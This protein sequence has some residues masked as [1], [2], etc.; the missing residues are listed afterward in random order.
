MT[1]RRPLL[2]LFLAPKTA[3]TKEKVKDVAAWPTTTTALHQQE[4]MIQHSMLV[5]HH[6][7]L[8]CV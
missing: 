1:L 8:H 3:A 4:S 5:H 6:S 7:Q 2:L